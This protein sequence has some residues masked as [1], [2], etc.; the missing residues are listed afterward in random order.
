MLWIIK[1]D[2]K[3]ARHQEAGSEDDDDDD[4]LG[5]EEDEDIDEA[6]TGEIV[7]SDEQ[8]EDS[9]AIVGGEGADKVLPEDSDGGMDDD[10]MFGM[11]TILPRS[12]K[13]KRIRLVVKLLSPSLS[14]SNSEFFHFWKFT[15]MKIEASVH[16][17]Q[18]SFTKCQ[19]P[20]MMTNCCQ[21]KCGICNWFCLFVNIV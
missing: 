11:D 14:S 4:L 1:K 16:C 19:M 7:E 10:A 2:L 12:L 20:P 15:C 5:I 9:E 3:P 17:F 8:S 6:E 21:L 18:L 13:R